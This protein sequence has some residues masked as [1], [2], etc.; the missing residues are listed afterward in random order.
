VQRHPHDRGTHGVSTVALSGGVF[1]N[2]LLL[3]LTWRG[4]REA[5]FDVLRH[6]RVPA[7]DGGLALGQVVVGAAPAVHIVDLAEATAH[8]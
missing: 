8:H 7:N 1:T 6:C 5:G 2:A 4:L 3:S